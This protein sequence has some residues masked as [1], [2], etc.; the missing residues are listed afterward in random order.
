MTKAGSEIAKVYPVLAASL[1]S[2]ALEE[3]FWDVFIQSVIEE[4][5]RKFVNNE[6][7][8]IGLTIEEVVAR[9]GKIVVQGGKGNLDAAISR[10]LKEVGKE[11][12]ARPTK[13]S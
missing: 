12:R 2:S 5:M 8:S 4:L 6:L 10:T 9:V 3:I 7:A 13:S 1:D 11:L